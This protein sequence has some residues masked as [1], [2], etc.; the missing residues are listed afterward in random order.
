MIFVA[1]GIGRPSAALAQD[2]AAAEALFDKGLADMNAG[3]FE[4]GCPKL[5]ES[6][7]IDPRA[8]GLFTLA[9]CEYKRG[10]VATATA[11]YAEFMRLVDAMTPAKRARQAERVRLARAAAPDLARRVPTLTLRVTPNPAPPGVTIERNGTAL[12]AGSLGEPMPVDPGIHMVVVRSKRGGKREVEVIVGEG[13]RRTVDID[14]S[15]PGAAPEAAA[16]T[17]GPVSNDASGSRRS[18]QQTFGFVVGS[19]GLAGLGAGAAT[20]VLALSAKSVADDNCVGTICND[21]GFAAVER[22]RTFGTVSTIALAAGGGLAATGLVLILTA[23]SGSA[24]GTQAISIGPAPH[25]AGFGFTAAGT[26]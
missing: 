8:G 11:R 1:L 18:G 16:V 23:P 5:E 14:A 4:A 13:D 26:F 6:Y 22:G 2:V 20:G 7:R 24:L 3:R 10:R 21:D 12:G 17:P 19:L 25:A 9:E 15:D